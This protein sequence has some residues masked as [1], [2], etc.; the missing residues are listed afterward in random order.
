MVSVWFA[1]NKRA[2]PVFWR[3]DPTVCWLNAR[4]GDLLVNH[5]FIVG[6]SPC[7]G[8]VHVTGMLVSRGK[9]PKMVLIQ[10]DDYLV[11][12]NIN[13]LFSISYM[14]YMGCHPSHWLI[15]FK[16]GTL[17]P[18]PVMIWL[19]LWSNMGWS[20]RNK[21]CA[22]EIPGERNVCVLWYDWYGRCPEMRV[23]TQIIQFVYF[24]FYF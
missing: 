15:F 22:S 7:S 8:W 10:I 14:I 16:M 9:Y 18:Q 19:D 23:I 13:G 1:R 21:A 17:H 20:E 5:H 12:W 3:V 6:E 4:F 24:E 2:N 11:V